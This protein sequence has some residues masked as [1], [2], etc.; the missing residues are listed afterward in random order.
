MVR[1]PIFELIITDFTH[2]SHHESFSSHI[3]KCIFQIPWAPCIYK[4]A[5]KL[6]N[7]IQTCI[8]VLRVNMPTIQIIPQWNTSSPLTPSPPPTAAPLPT[9]PASGSYQSH[10]PMGYRKAIWVAHHRLLPRARLVILGSK[11]QVIRPPPTATPI[12]RP[13]TSTEPPPHSSASPVKLTT[14]HPRAASIQLEGDPS[15]ISLG[16]IA[17]TSHKEEVTELLLLEPWLWGRVAWTVCWAS[18][19]MDLS[20]NKGLELMEVAVVVIRETEYIHRQ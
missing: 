20:I 7:S 19:G 11:L 9:P 13:S 8:K 15:R 4:I 10:R 18:R 12:Y 5:A 17:A 2:F 14:R 16:K 3:F 1:S 6:L